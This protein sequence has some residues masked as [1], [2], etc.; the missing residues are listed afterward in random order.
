MLLD[1]RMVD[2]EHRD[3]M[4]TV[5]VI[6]IEIK[7]DEIFDSSTLNGWHR[8]NSR[9]Q[10]SYLHLLCVVWMKSVFFLLIRNRLHI[11]RHVSEGSAIACRNRARER[12][13]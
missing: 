3:V 10:Y 9:C 8:Q 4:E 1:S 6:V 7:V 2:T 5:A 12:S 13:R 11:M